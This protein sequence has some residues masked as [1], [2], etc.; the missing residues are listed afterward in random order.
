[1]GFPQISSR[2]VDKEGRIDQAWL[3]LLIMLWNRTGGQTGADASDFQYSDGQILGVLEA[4]RDELSD[5][6]AARPPATPADPSTDLV[7]P[8]I[9]FGDLLSRIQS[10]ESIVPGLGRM[11]AEVQQQ[12]QDAALA[13]PP[14][15]LDRQLLQDATLGVPPQAPLLCET[16]SWTP[17]LTF[18]TPGDLTVAYAADGQIGRLTKIGDLIVAYGRIVTSTFTHTTAA[19]NMQITGLPY[20]AMAVAAFN[21]SGKLAWAGI[22]KAN[23]TEVAVFLD[24]GASTITAKASGSGQA[25][26]NIAAADMPTAGT[27]QLEFV[28]AYKAAQP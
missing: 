12:L 23:Y 11:L 15:E 20:A 6:E 28:L 21:F 9:D 1:M 14:T 26:S 25:V 4:V 10:V 17:V 3:Q 24:S 13:P 5:L 2:F 19:G 7:R 18:A 22:T 16:G 8:P 27:V